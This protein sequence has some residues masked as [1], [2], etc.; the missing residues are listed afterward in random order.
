MPPLPSS[1]HTAT[2]CGEILYVLGGTDEYGALRLHMLHT[3]SFS[4]R[5]ATSLDTYYAPRLSSGHTAAL[6]PQV[7]RRGEV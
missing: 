4:W 5:E 6:M 3:P 7:A 2:L 1:S